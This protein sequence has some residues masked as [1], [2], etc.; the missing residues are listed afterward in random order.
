[1]TRMLSSHKHNIVF[2]HADF[3]PTN[4]IVKDGHVAGIIDW[5]MAGWYPE[6]WEFVNVFYVWRWQNDWGTHLLEIMQPYYCEQA[7]HARLVQV[8]L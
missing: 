8:L 6:H 7:I 5:E 1:M 2:T 4:V 3:R